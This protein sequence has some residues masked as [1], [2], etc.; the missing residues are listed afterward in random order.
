MKLLADYSDSDVA[1]DSLGIIYLATVGTFNQKG[2]DASALRLFKSDLDNADRSTWNSL[3]QRV[4]VDEVRRPLLIV[5]DEAHNLS[6][7]QTA[8]LM[9]LEP[10]GFLL[11]SATPKLPQAILRVINDLKELLGW[12]DADLTTYV[13]SGE[14]V[15]AGLVK[16]E[17]RLAGYQAQ[18][19]ETIA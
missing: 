8:L 14:V 15:E 16:G 6:D 2:K 4:T 1:D 10:D 19:E 18:M 11:A 12:G 5:Y 9:E 3:K 7:Q 17:V 13:P